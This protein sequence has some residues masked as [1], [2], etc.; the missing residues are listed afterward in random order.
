MKTTIDLSRLV[1]LANFGRAPDLATA[2]AALAAGRLFDVDTQT[3][4]EDCVVDADCA[5]DALIEIAAWGGLAEVPES[6][7]ATRLTAIR[8]VSA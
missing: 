6:W 3:G 8:E 7:T 5:E 2:R 4:G 1:Y